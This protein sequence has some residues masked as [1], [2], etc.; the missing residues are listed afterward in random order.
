MFKKLSLT[1]LL[2]VALLGPI[3][4]IKFLQISS[5]IAMGAEM[6]KTG[7]PP[8]PVATYVANEQTW[9]D[10]L[11]AVGSLQ[12]VQGV[13]LAA[14]LGGTV[15][16]IAVENGAP[17][18]KDDVLVRLDTSVEKAQLAAAEA[19]LQLAHLQLD[20]S[21]NL[22]GQNTISQSEFDSSDATA[23]AA[24]AE[25]AYV[26]AQIAKKT[27][28]APFAGRVGIRMI[29]LGQTLS[30]GALV[31][32]LQ[33]LNPIFIDFTL[34]QQ[35]L[36]Q[37]AP[38]QTLRVKLDGIDAA[39]EGKVTAINPEVDAATRNVRVQG[40]LANPAEQ[41]RPGMFAEVTLVLPATRKVVA[42]PA[43]AVIYA[44]FGDS[45]YIVEEKEGRTVARQQ[46]VRLGAARGDFI[47]IADGLA[48][49]A[50]VVSAGAFKLQNGAAIVIDDKMQPGF[51]L[52]PKPN[53]T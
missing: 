19:N 27:L 46:F 41:L 53:N 17:V 35:R 29:N 33:A 34:P 15:V 14:E 26:R 24:A 16:E 31:I 21:K 2:L 47:A 8:S 43:T 6:E 45:V 37:V 48:A 12:A 42:V 7:M 51:S 50:R 23:K 40:T 3:V 22:L 36:S 10:T 30:A 49:G 4:V 44:P 32:P 11:V 38:G 39:F 1:G 18:K 9:E 25:V 5:L 20:R 52:D 13:T 28:R